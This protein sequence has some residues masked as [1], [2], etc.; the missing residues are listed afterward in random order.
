[1]DCPQD[2]LQNALGVSVKK[3]ENQEGKNEQHYKG[4]AWSIFYRGFFSQCATHFVKEIDNLLAVDRGAK[5]KDLRELSRGRFYFVH[6]HVLPL[7][8]C[9]YVCVYVDTNLY[10]HV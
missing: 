8:G 7:E 3:H 4:P 6:W 5:I 2:S 9:V 10:E 1:M